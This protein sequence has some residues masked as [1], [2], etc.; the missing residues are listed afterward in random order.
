MRRVGVILA[1][2][3]S[4]RMGGSDKACL[5]LGGKRLID[6]VMA[7][8]TPQVDAMLIAGPD[9]YGSGLPTVADPTDGP[10]GPAAGL[11]A[12]GRHITAGSR[13]TAIMIT[14]PVDCPFLP[15]YLADHLCDGDLP[16]V[17]NAAG[18]LQPAFGAWEIR[19]LLDAM[20]DEAI[21]QSPSLRAVAR[22]CLARETDF[23]DGDAFFNIN[24]P[25]DLEQARNRPRP[26]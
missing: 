7:R 1:G 5:E 8:L 3:Q 11:L 13:P 24:T 20:A 12:A 23:G 9:D 4:R 2:G 14:V 16:A 15:T 17:A 18:R 21:R 19:P 26:S 25:H 22:A 10:V 6:H